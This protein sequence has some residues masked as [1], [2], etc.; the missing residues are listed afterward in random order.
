MAPEIISGKGYS[1]SAD[2]WSF[3][4]TLFEIFYDYLPFGQGATDVLDIYQ[5]I[6][7]KKLILPYDPK[8]NQLNSFLKI[9]LS[10]NIMHRVCNYKLLKCH[11]FFQDFQFEQLLNHSIKPPFIPEIVNDTKNLTICNM[12]L[13]DYFKKDFIDNNTNDIEKNEE[14]I[15]VM[16]LLEDF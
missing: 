2:Y 15:N 1:F 4:I 16:K 5:Q 12:S 14:Y 7:G 13:L 3:G 6:L 9:I 11:P 10:K 8:F